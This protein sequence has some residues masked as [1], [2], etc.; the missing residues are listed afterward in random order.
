[1]S[2]SVTLDA[3]AAR[4]AVES[5]A[6]RLGA[7]IER[8]ANAIIA[9]VD[10][11]MARALRRVSVERGVDPRRC[12]LVA[13]GGGGPLHACSLASQLGMTRILVPP[14]AGVLSALG[15]AIAA[16]RRD[17][18]RSVMRKA[19]DLERATVAAM[20]EELATQAGDAVERRWWAHARY[21]GQGHELDIPLTPDDDGA[22]VAARFA[23]LHATRAGFTLERPVEIVS[24]RHAAF[25]ASREA[26]LGVADGA[27]PPIEGPAIVPLPDAAMRVEAGWRATAL[28]TGGFIV[29]RRA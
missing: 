23:Q 14:H 13:F 5:L 8:V 16:E 3:S 25:G 11:S 15:L 7:P 19:A 10:A 6:N 20:C 21:V 17:V 12:V 18:M 28:P 9:A 24:V 22:A 27:A 26:S 1:M 29:E 2:G 4:H